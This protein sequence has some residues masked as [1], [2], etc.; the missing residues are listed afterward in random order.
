MFKALLDTDV[1]LFLWLDRL[2]HPPWMTAIMVA[3]TLA[4]SFGFVWL[5]IAG[6]VAVKERDGG[7]LW[8]TTLTILFVYALINLGLKPLVIRSRPHRCLAVAV[9]IPK[10]Q[11]A[12][13]SFP[14]SH[15]AASTA[16]AYALSRTIP[17]AS[18]V[19]WPL[20]LTISVSLIYLGNH[21]PLD[22]IV[23]WLI[24]LACGFFVTG[25]VTYSRRWQPKS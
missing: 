16:G 7:N 21:Y 18:S 9:D 14:S 2:P 1:A 8:R 5:A 13:S 6:G 15:S 10:L 23:G 24:G 20:A 25:G 12:T 4:G 17:A 22:V 19:L 11:P 3:V